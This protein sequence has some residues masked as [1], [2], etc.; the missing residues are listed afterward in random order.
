[1]HGL[2]GRTCRSKEKKKKKHGV[3]VPSIE[4]KHSR[5][6]QLTLSGG[7]G[8]GEEEGKTLIFQVWYTLLNSQ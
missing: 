5:Y 2:K 1:M 6:S 8:R 4:S 3:A 7:G